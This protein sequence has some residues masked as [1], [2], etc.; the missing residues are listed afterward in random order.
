MTSSVIGS[1]DTID[2]DWMTDV[3]G[4]S[5]ALNG[6]RVSEIRVT[7]RNTSANA[8]LARI[9]LTWTPP[10]PPE[11]PASLFVKMTKDANAPGPHLPAGQKEV[12]FYRDAHTF[13][14]LPVPRCYD[15]ARDEESGRFHLMLEDLAETH[16]DVTH[17]PVAPS[18]EQCKGIV[19]AFA[20]FHAAWWEDPRLGVSVGDA[21]DPESYPSHLEK[22]VSAFADR[23]G[24][25]LPPERLRRYERLLMGAG[26]LLQR[27]RTG[28]HVTLAHGDAH[29]WNLLYPRDSDAAGVRLI[30]WD[31]YIGPLTGAYDL[32]YFMAVHWYPERRRRYEADLLAHYH[33][34]LE[35]AG[36]RGYTLD[37][38]RDDYRHAVLQHLHTPVFQS[39]AGVPPRVWW[40]HL[41]RIMLAFED[42]DCEALL[43]TAARG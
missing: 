11:A 19:A 17:W 8:S 41:E 15:T 13:A 14:G 26:G 22:S 3:L 33:Q 24:D 1:L 23:L 21:P 29:A 9:A 28:R 39:G 12:A 18:F 10:A 36:V 43:D 38:L 40:D 32:A 30:D 27:Y 25:R 20:R 4:R 34:V 42:L 6:A 5:C 31:S 37:A 35:A 16:G 2:P 7:E